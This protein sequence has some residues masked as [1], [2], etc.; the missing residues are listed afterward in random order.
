[1][2]M[3][4]PPVATLG[5]P[6][7][8]ESG[9]ATYLVCA[10]AV[11]WNVSETAR[12]VAERFAKND[13][14][15]GGV[16]TLDLGA[17][18]VAA[19]CAWPAKVDSLQADFLEVEPLLEGGPSEARIREGFCVSLVHSDRLLDGLGDLSHWHCELSYEIAGFIEGQRGFR[20]MWSE[21]S[22][23]REEAL[24]FISAVVP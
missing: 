2:Q 6:A 10:D 16:V 4:L 9:T 18:F 15:A 22:K 12:I 5:A 20:E 21:A 11:R 19:D 7:S 3:L 14:L 24:G 17:R 13:F 23:V 1:M 8:I